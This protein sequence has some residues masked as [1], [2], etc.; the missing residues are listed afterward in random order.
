MRSEHES[1]WWVKDRCLQGDSVYVRRPSFSRAVPKSLIINGL[2][3]SFVLVWAIS[4]AFRMYQSLVMLVGE[5]AYVHL[6]RLQH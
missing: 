6:R 5:S 3:S 2:S 4:M 1:L